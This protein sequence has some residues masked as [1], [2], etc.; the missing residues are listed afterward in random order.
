MLSRALDAHA[1]SQPVY[2]LLVALFMDL[3]RYDDAL[4]AVEVLQLLQRSTRKK[5]TPRRLAA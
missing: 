3:E 4:T 2:W 1:Q 5:R